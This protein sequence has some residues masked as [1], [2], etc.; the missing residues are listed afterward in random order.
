MQ[1]AGDGSLL[2]DRPRL[3]R[4]SFLAL[5]AAV[6]TAP[7]TRSEGGKVAGGRLR[8]HLF[9]NSGEAKRPLLVLVHGVSTEPAALISMVAAAASERDV[10]LMAPDFHAKGFD[11]YQR[12]GT[13]SEPLVAGRALADALAEAQRRFGMPPG[14]VDLMG[15]SGGGQ[16]VHRFALFF[17]QL[18]RR[19]VIAAPGWFTYL[20]ESRPYPYGIGPSPAVHAMSPRV[21]EFLRLPKLV[22]VGALDTVRD[23]QLRRGEADRQGPNRLERARRWVDHVNAEAAARGLGPS[24]KLEIL[25]HTGHSVAQALRRGR[26]AD[27][28]LDFLGASTPVSQ[29]RPATDADDD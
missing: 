4:R 25:P 18:V 20:D 27:K 5:A 19:A 14:Q 13:A 2:P 10:P 29:R 1:Q 21:T 23:R 24:A 26:L 17:P 3:C 6:A 7:M 12:L 9:V 28:M 8:F 22:A 11:D 15:F 16:F